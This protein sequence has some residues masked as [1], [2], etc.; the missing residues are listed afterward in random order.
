MTLGVE[1]GGLAMPRDQKLILK[2]LRHIHGNAGDTGL[3]EVPAVCGHSSSMVAEHVKLAA[4]MG[5]VE[6]VSGNLMDSPTLMRL[7][8]KGHD[9][10]E[11]SFD[12]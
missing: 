6:V 7:T 2:I 5:L 8:A 9:K 11:E 12:C 1:H 10:V 4:E 3:I